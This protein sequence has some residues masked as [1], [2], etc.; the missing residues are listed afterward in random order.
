MKYLARPQLR[1]LRLFTSAADTGSQ[2]WALAEFRAPI[3]VDALTHS[4]G[5]LDRRGAD[6]F[7][8]YVPYSKAF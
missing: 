8:L 3:S 1:Q 2:L 5:D 4:V 6:V 7:N